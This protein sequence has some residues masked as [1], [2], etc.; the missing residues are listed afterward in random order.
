MGLKA[1]RGPSLAVR[2]SSFNHPNGDLCSFVH[3][4]AFNHAVNVLLPLPDR[5]EPEADAATAAALA[6]FAAAAEAVSAVQFC[7]ARVDLWALA[8]ADFIKVSHSAVRHG[9]M[10][11][12]AAH[13][14]QTLQAAV[15]GAACGA[16]TGKQPNLGRSAQAHVAVDEGPRII[17]VSANT[18]LD[19]TDGAALT[20][21]GRLHLALTRGA[22]ERL[23]L[24]GA[25]S[26]TG[27]GAPRFPLSLRVSVGGGLSL[28]RRAVTPC[29]SA[30]CTLQ[31]RRRVQVLAHCLLVESA[32]MGWMIACT[33][34]LA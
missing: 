17:A 9:P 21:D 28:A 6:A 32:C 27:A 33:H 7:A 14:C 29:H 34:V 2:L 18:P 30:Q 5:A 3:G 13:G 22:H 24:V 4:H 25:R 15:S 10:H 12:T 1:R 31:A 16:R 26:R 19:R 8:D 20:P 11:P 23:G